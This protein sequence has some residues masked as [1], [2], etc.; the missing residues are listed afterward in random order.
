MTLAEL[1]RKLADL[2]EG[3]APPESPVDVDQGQRFRL[4]TRVELF[5]GHVVLETE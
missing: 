4:L 2:V 5:E 1:Q 3:G